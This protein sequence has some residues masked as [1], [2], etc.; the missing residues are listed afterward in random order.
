MDFLESEALREAYTVAPSDSVVLDT[1]EVSRGSEASIF[2]TNNYTAFTAT[3]E[4]ASVVTFQAIPFKINLPSKAKDTLPVMKI[5]IANPN[6]IVS[7]YLRA[8]KAAKQPVIVKFR[9]F[10]ATSNGTVITHQLPTPM[11]FHIGPVNF[12]INQVDVQCLFPNISN[13]K[14]PNESYTVRLFPGLR[15]W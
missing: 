12:G 8:A 15:G 3:L 11:T 10:L 14:F 6:Q 5:S 4:T 13:K 2:L 1:L 7:D 9:P